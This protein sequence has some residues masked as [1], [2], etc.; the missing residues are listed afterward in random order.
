[1]PPKAA[2]GGPK[3]RSPHQFY[4]DKNFFVV[5]AAGAAVVAAAVVFLVFGVFLVFLVFRA[6]G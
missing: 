4:L 2:D 6:V 3:G 5:A 1:M